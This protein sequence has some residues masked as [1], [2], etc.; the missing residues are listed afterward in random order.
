[1]DN[2]DSDP[3]DNEFI[4]EF[5]DFTRP[6]LNRTRGRNLKIPRQTEQPSGVSADDDVFVM[7]RRIQFIEKGI[8]AGKV[9]LMFDALERCQLTG[10]WYR[11]SEREDA[12]DLFGIWLLTL[13]AKDKARLNE[14]G[15]LKLEEKGD[16]RTAKLIEDE[17]EQLFR[18]LRFEMVRKHRGTILFVQQEAAKMNARF[19][20]RLGR[21]LKK[22]GIGFENTYSNLQRFLLITWATLY[23][24]QKGKFFPPLCCFSD[25]ALAEYVRIILKTSPISPDTIR[26]TWERLGLRKAQHIEILKFKREGRKTIFIWTLK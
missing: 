26:K 23:E 18:A 15:L 12:I 17:T 7:M 22:P 5:L 25:P 24:K 19:F 4:K 8:K 9:N 13:I 16:L 14:L 2:H 20:E 11:P 6:L 1:M 3:S 10:R 21:V